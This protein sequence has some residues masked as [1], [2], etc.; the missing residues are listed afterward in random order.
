MM[1]RHSC[2]RFVVDSTTEDAPVCVAASRVAAAMVSEL[3]VHAAENVV[4]LFVETLAVLQ[5]TPI[6]DSRLVKGLHDHLRPCGS[7]A[8]S[9]RGPLRS[10]TAFRITVLNPYS[11]NSHWIST[12]AIL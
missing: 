6:L 1:S 4:E 2:T 3:R 10:S 8:A 7:Q 9:E 12:G 5:T 11:T